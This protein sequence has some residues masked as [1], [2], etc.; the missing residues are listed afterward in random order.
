V[1]LQAREDD[2]AGARRVLG[3]VANV[4]HAGR[5]AVLDDHAGDERA[6]LDGE[7]RAL[8]RGA[9]VAVGRRPAPPVALCELERAGAV[10]HVAVEV[11]VG[12]QTVD[13]RRRQ[14]G[15]ASGWMYGASSTRSGPPLP[16]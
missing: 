10:L 13:Q 4:A 7:V 9:Q 2:L 12:A 11:V 15:G 14:P 1:V 8:G 3:A 6:G 16:W 5:T